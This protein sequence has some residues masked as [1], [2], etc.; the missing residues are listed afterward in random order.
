MKRQNGKKKT[1]KGIVT[2]DLKAQNEA[3]VKQLDDEMSSL[4]GLREYVNKGADALAARLLGGQNLY[5]D[6]M[7]EILRKRL[8]IAWEQS[9]VL[10]EYRK[11]L[12]SFKGV[13]VRQQM[14]QR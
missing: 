8:T 1:T 4:D 7:V 12:E 14:M 2:V 5:T 11:E 13:M 3:I 6:N 10:M 9:R